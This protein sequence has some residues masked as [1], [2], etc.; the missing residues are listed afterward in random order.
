M[1]Y[2]WERAEFPPCNIP[3]KN[4][5]LSLYVLAGC[6]RC[7]ILNAM[8][9]SLLEN[10]LHYVFRNKK[11]LQ[12]AMTH[13]SHSANHN[14][15]LEFLGDSILNC[16]VAA[17]LFKRFSELNEGDLSRVRAN[18]VKQQSLY[19]IAQSLN[20]AEALRLGEGELKNGGSQRPSILADTLEAILGAIYLDGGFAAVHTVIEDL[21][22]P[23]L[24]HIDPETLGKDAKT[25]LQESLQGRKIPLPHY[26]VVAT[27]GAAHSQ[28]FEVEC[29]VPIYEIKVF[30]VGT[31]RRVAEQAAAKRALEA[32]QTLPAA[33]L[34]SPKRVKYARQPK[35]SV[36]GKT[37]VKL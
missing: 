13:R 17:L 18:L 19:E 34:A 26:T 22:A 1:I 29:A 5:S 16:T 2:G 4:G 7:V 30:G 12:Q 11:Y 15:R 10:R 35:P 33:A 25:L 28:Q 3:S 9:L 27:R 23:F 36:L 21:Y 20:L 6:A 8:P 31:S 32:I 14:E 37:K 24:K